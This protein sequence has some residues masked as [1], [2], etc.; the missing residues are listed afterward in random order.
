MDRYG[1]KCENRSPKHRIG[2]DLFLR[3]SVTRIGG[4]PEDFDSVNDLTV[5]IWHMVHPWRTTNDFAVSK[6]EISLQFAASRQ[7]KDGAYGVTV[8]YTKPDERSEDGVRRDAVDIPNAFVLVPIS[9][10]CS[11]SGVVELCAHVQIAADGANGST[12]YIGD[13]GNWWIA[14]K[15]TGNP[16]KGADGEPGTFAYP[17]FFVDPFSGTLTAKCPFFM[18]DGD[19]K[20]IDGYLKIGI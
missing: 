15:D 11:C 4:V 13:N 2:T 8:R 14:G 17:V 6:G 3:I 20:L 18:D 16:S 10:P 7:W 9:Q 12:P 1:I 19:I 5:T